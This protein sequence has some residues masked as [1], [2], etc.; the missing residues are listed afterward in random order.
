[1][2]TS[3]LK[4]TKK[5]LAIDPNDDTFDLDIITFIN[6]ALSAIQQLGVNEGFQ[7]ED[8]SAV[9]TDFC[10]TPEWLGLIRTIV[11]LRV[12][13]LFDPPNTSYTQQA[14]TNQI[15]QLEWRLNVNRENVQ[16]TDPNPP[17]IIDPEAA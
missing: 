14:L 1:M 10:D 12:R 6:S 2:E 15:E 3:I 4:S 17:I 16:W 11:Y 9:W 7:I 13:M 8:E 5:I